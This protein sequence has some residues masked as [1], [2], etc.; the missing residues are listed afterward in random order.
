MVIMP[1]LGIN[2]CASSMMC[3]MLVYCFSRV[4][5]FN[6]VLLSMSGVC[7]CIAFHWHFQWQDVIVI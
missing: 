5:I 2:R 6:V 1:A 7:D 3:R 4:Y